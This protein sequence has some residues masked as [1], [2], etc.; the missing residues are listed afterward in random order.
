M[1]IHTNLFGHPCWICSA[2]E[3]YEHVHLKNKFTFKY[4][5]KLEFLLV[6]STVS[7]HF[8]CFWRLKLSCHFV[9]MEVVMFMVMIHVLNVKAIFFLVF[10]A[11][12]CMELQPIYLPLITFT[13]AC[14]EEPLRLK[15]QNCNTILG[16]M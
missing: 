12:A 8:S 5:F 11:N 4:L 14:C 2:S 15:Y 7:H 3:H 6:L 10:G 13:L 16:F 9:T 1:Q